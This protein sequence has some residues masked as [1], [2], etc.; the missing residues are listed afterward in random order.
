MAQAQQGLF[1]M[2][3]FD[4][5]MLR[6]QDIME[7]AKGIEQYGPGFAAGVLA[8]QGIGQIGRSFGLR[9]QYD[10]QAD[11]T[12]QVKQWLKENLPENPD[13]I[14][15]YE[16]M[17][18][19]F[20]RFGMPEQAAQVMSKLEDMRN[21]AADRSYK[22]S[23]AQYKQT[24]AQADIMSARASMVRAMNDNKI[25][26]SDIKTLSELIYN[27]PEMKKGLIQ[28]FAKDN[29]VLADVLNNVDTSQE[30]GPPE[31][32]EQVGDLL[33]KSRKTG[34]WRSVASG[35]TVKVDARTNIDTGEGYKLMEQFRS[36]V[37]KLDDKINSAQQA[38]EVI[39]QAK[40][41]S[42]AAASAASRALSRMWES[43]Q[44]SQRDVEAFSNVGSVEQRLANSV[45]K[46]LDGTYTPRT[47]DDF[48][49]LAITVERILLKQREEVRKASMTW[50]KRNNLTEDELNA[51]FPARSPSVRAG[52][53]NVDD[54]GAAAVGRW[55]K[56]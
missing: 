26:P 33:Q 43:S 48:M 42:P 34:Q 55:S 56:K 49:Q 29:P 21:N 35:T 16:K 8:Q 46:W 4:A 27:N 10:E 45:T 11:K 25:K 20:N 50:G 18:E 44:L 38:M 31:W 51:L 40:D 30:W 32:N 13:P 12:T 41:G 7:S 15:Y 23:D 2:T 1:G 37:S 24:K 54:Q 22:L 19:A 28:D 5:N 14:Q 36:R 39:Q 47:Y 53:I 9:D 52:G 6:R 17:A 3:P